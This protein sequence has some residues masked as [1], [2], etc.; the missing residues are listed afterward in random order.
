MYNL[1]VYVWKHP[2]TMDWIKERI[3]HIGIP[4]DIFG[5]FAIQ[6]TFCLLKFFLCVFGSLQTSLLCIGGE[7]VRGGL[8]AVAVGVSDM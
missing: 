4:L 6:M 1:S 3:A 2:F 5:F 7:L 8:V